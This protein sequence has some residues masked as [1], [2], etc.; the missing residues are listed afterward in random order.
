MLHRESADRNIDR[1]YC[2]HGVGS[3]GGVAVRV[4]QSGGGGGSEFESVDIKG[5]Q[6]K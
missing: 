6:I 1:G 3:E 2:S 4:G 5:A